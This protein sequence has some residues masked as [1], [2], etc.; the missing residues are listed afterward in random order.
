MEQYQGSPPGGMPTYPPPRPPAQPQD[1]KA[2]AAFVLG[3]ICLAVF[4][5]NFLIPF[6]E[7]VIGAISI[8]LAISARKGGNTSGKVTAGLICSI[9]GVSLS[10]LWW[11]SCFMCTCAT[12]TTPFWLTF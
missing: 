2:T 6:L 5:V 7:V 9:I 11:V 8:I 1:G 10:I 12:C 4:M 3:I